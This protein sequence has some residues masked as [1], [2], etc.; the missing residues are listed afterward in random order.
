MYIERISKKFIVPLLTLIIAGCLGDTEQLEELPSPIQLSEERESAFN[1]D[2]SNRA[3]WWKPIVAKDGM[4]SIVFNFDGHEESG[5]KENSNHKLTLATKF[6]NQSWEYVTAKLKNRNRYW[7]ACDD[8]GH[9]QPTIAIDGDGRVHVWAGMHSEPDGC[10]YFTFQHDLEEFEQNDAFQNKGSFTYPIPAAAPNGDIFLAI[11]NLP[12]SQSDSEV[13]RFEGQGELHTWNNGNKEWRKV[14]SFA[15]HTFTEHGSNA[16]AYPDDL[17]VD[18]NGIVHILW[19]WAVNST[20]DRRYLGSYLKFDPVQQV[21]LTADNEMVFEPVNLSTLTELPSLTFEPSNPFLDRGDYIQSA[22]LEYDGDY[23]SPCIVYRVLGN[24]GNNIAFTRWN[25]GDWA[26]PELLYSSNINSFATI[27]ASI[28]EDKFTVYYA[29]VG[30]GVYK[31]SKSMTS[32]N[33]SHSV[34]YESESADIRLSLA[35]QYQTKILYISEL[36]DNA[37]GATIKILSL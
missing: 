7:S 12:D 29:L 32:D 34:L 6:D 27:D 5:C 22:K 4:L 18:S 30:E 24:K 28:D 2:A 25:D 15:A 19:E 3:G 14:S 35:A 1:A 11:R 9:R 26:K 16:I 17:Y 37:N 10:C 8:L 36:N 31:S 33:W 20:S 23:C 21:F 13:N